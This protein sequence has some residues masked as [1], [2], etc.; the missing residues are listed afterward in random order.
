MSGSWKLRHMN[1]NPSPDV[2]GL[3]SDTAGVCFRFRTDFRK[4]RIFW[5][6]AKPVIRMWNMA[7]SGAD[8]I[9]V[10]Q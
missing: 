6:T 2:R 4:L 3:Q 8:G 7:P 10:Y 5:K 1:E 9:D